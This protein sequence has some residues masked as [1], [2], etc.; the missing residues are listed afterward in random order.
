[1][2]DFLSLP[3]NNFF[4]RGSRIISTTE[5]VKMQTIKTIAI[6]VRVSTEEQAEEGFSIAAQLDTLRS[7]AKQHRY[8]IHNEYADEGI[9]GKSIEKRLALQQ[10]LKDA[11]AGLFQEVIVW[12][13]NRISRNQLDLLNIVDTLHKNGVAFRSYSEN[14][15]TE[16]PMGRFALQ[17]MGSVA[18]L[19]RNTIVENVKM[20]MKQ[21]ARMGKW[22][23]GTVLGYQSVEL[24]G[25]TSRKR[26]ETR[27][28]IVES[29]AQIVRMIYEKYASGRGMRAIANELNHAGYRTKNG[30]PFSMV[31]VKIIILNPVYKGYIRFNKHQDWEQKRRK[32][33]NP[34]PILVPGEHAPIIE[35]E[36]WDKVAERFKAMSHTPIR[37][38]GTL[39]FTGVMRC[40]QC[41][42]G[43]VAQHATRK[44]KNGEIKYTMYY[45][46][47]Q[48]TSK[49]SAVCRANSVRADDAEEE[50]LSKIDK[51]I[52]NPKLALDVADKINSKNSKA[53]DLLQTEL[54]QVTRELGDIQRRV[55]KYFRLYEDDSID[56]EQLK[57]R[58]QELGETK[59]A[60][61]RRKQVIE[62]QLQQG[63]EA[64][65]SLEKIRLVLADFRRV[66]RKTS[67]DKRKSL[68]HALIK[69]ITVAEDRKIDRIEWNFA[70]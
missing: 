41:G 56:S 54:D 65:V 11:K 61:A 48:F 32:G 64:E 60:L 16:T 59:T 39:P 15:E 1:M 35:P 45:Q 5:R 51:I 70:L 6:Y 57:A 29:E 37:V 2:F 62:Q 8:L 19:E 44:N 34:E 30:Q 22:N 69:R 36:L 23:G 46:C 25:S 3:E 12:K 10:L 21:R 18:E 38:V 66:F 43:M 20:G 33:T 42:A 52:R 17:M 13:I 4:N 7:Y 28:E 49:G 40:P 26:K 31:T 67:Q 58:I 53:P 50:I 24:E 14:F 9:S 63:D 27:L 55:D 68:V 47:G